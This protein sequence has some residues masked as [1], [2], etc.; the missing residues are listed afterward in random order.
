[1]DTRFVASGPRTTDSTGADAALRLA[2]STQTLAH[3]ALLRL[4]PGAQRVD[5][6][7]GSLWITQDGAATDVVLEAGESFRPDAGRGAIVYALSDARV[8][9]RIE[10]GLPQAP[11][12][13]TRRSW[14]RGWQRLTALG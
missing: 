11:R 8:G 9:L 1:M 4:P 12:R 7:G 14:A 2:A 6:L 5:C 10:P 3:R 13:A